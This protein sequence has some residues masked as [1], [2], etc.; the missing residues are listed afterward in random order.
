MDVD[1]ME[2]ESYNEAE[3]HPAQAESCT[4]KVPPVG[5]ICASEVEKQQKEKCEDSEKEEEDSSA[6]ELTSEPFGEGEDCVAGS[7]DLN[8]RK[9]IQA[10]VDG[11]KKR[12]STF[13]RGCITS[14]NIEGRRS[15]CPGIPLL[16]LEGNVLRLIY[17]NRI[18][19]LYSFTVIDSKVISECEK[20]QIL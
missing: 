1:E 16:S 19:L 15:I 8:V 4:E 9:D 6:A 5:K 2:K 11:V 7:S 14:K 13:G 10:V 17:N 18:Y 12:R 20:I 3:K